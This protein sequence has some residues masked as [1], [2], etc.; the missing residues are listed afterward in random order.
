MYI[1]DEY[2]VIKDLVNL[3]FIQKQD[4]TFYRATASIV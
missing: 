2:Y 4:D 1:N 3:V